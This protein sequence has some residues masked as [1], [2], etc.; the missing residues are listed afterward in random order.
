M[1]IAQPQIFSRNE[2]CANISPTSS[3]TTDDKLSNSCINTGEN[4]TP[5][6]SEVIKVESPDASEDVW[7]RPT[8]NEDSTVT[9]FNSTPTTSRK[10]EHT[11]TNLPSNISLCSISSPPIIQVQSPE[12]VPESKLPAVKFATNKD[13]VTK[14]NSFAK[15]P[16]KKKFEIYTE[17]SET[18]KE[19]NSFEIYEDTV[20]KMPVIKCK[21]LNSLREKPKDDSIIF[22]DTIKSD[23]EIYEDTVCRLPVVKINTCND[24]TKENEG[25]QIILKEKSDCQVSSANH[26][27]SILTEHNEKSSSPT[28][29]LVK[30][31]NIL[32]DLNEVKTVTFSPELTTEIQ[33]DSETECKAPIKPRTKSQVVVKRIVV[34][35]N[36]NKKE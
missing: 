30:N 18:S 36:F 11:Q 7:E 24:E 13:N 8:S 31:R 6:N 21:D 9:G 26:L 17:E 28:S 33:I 14:L 34:K 3:T 20:C 12:H 22:C 4:K 5:N 23:F 35:S 16:F 19:S 15:T 2:A 10:F 25:S 1:E 27:G 32:D 29:I